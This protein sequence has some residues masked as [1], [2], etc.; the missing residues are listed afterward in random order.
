MTASLRLDAEKVC[1]LC[2]H[3]TQVAHKVKCR[4]AVYIGAGNYLLT[5]Y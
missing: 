5:W 2:G 3:Q 1:K 4:M